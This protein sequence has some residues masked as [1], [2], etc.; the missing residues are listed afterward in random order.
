MFGCL[1]LRWMA[2]SSRSASSPWRVR[3]SERKFTILMATRRR[4]SECSASRTLPCVPS[5]M[6]S[7]LMYGPI[8]LYGL[9]PLYS[10]AEFSC[11]SSM[12]IGLHEGLR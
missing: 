5:P 7:P 11:S 3:R 10:M 6:T 2:I 9:L 4:L 12:F 1:S 8:I